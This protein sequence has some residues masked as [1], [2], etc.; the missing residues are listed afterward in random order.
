LYT[1][2][3]L[4]PF[5]TL[6]LNEVV[7]TLAVSTYACLSAAFV[8]AAVI[9]TFGATPKL[10]AKVMVAAVPS[11]AAQ[12]PGVVSIT[13]TPEVSLPAEALTVGALEHIPPATP[14]KVVEPEVLLVMM[15][16]AIVIVFTLNVLL[17][18]TACVTVSE[19]FTV[20]ACPV[21]PMET[22]AAVAVPI[23]I[24]GVP[25]VYVPVSIVMPPEAPAEA[26]PDLI[27][28]APVPVV[29]VPDCKV[30]APD[31]PAVALPD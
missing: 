27:E 9:T 11:E 15:C 16:P 25:E 28:I 7:L 6:T 30:T 17:K 13:I 12:P 18:V 24:V 4:R 14:A 26:L 8:F 22:A 31:A 23:L 21:R 19:P 10:L 1:V 2:V 5:L 29:P 3:L 20:V